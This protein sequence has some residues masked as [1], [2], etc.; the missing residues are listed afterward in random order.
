MCLAPEGVQAS[1][2]GPLVH[3]SS[4]TQLQTFS[5]SKPFTSSNSDA[6]V[7][8]LSA[9]RH[10]LGQSACLNGKENLAPTLSYFT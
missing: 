4:Q 8:V 5:S 3:I 7:I 1:P 9:L 10:H 6:S 2:L